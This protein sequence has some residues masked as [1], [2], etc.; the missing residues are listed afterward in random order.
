MFIMSFD[1]MNINNGI[2]E[3]IMRTM[4]IIIISKNALI[5]IIDKQLLQRLFL[6]M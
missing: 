3:I 6:T 4:K 5:F 1:V 2:V